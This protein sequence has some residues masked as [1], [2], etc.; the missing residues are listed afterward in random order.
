LTA[1]PAGR[2]PATSSSDISFVTTVVPSVFQPAAASAVP[3]VAQPRWQPPEHG[4]M[5]CNVDEAFSSQRN[6]MGVDI[7]IHDKDGVFI[8]ARTVTFSDVYPVDIGEALSLYHTLQWVN[9]MHL[10]NI[11]FE[12]DSKTTKDAL[13]SGREDI[14]EFG[15]IIEASRSLLSS[16]FT[17]SRVEFV[18][19]QANVVTHT[20]AGETTFLASHTIY[21]HILSCIETLITNEML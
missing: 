12:V 4:R 1:A 8:L 17:N 11:Y 14:T 21:F 18:R 13:Y 20:L 2:K 15:N 9:D 7:C 3:A 6:K 5:K 16:K 19:R 10:D